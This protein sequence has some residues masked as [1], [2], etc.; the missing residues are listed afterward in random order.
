MFNRMVTL[1]LKLKRYVSYLIYEEFTVCFVEDPF[2][3]YCAYNWPDKLTDQVPP[4]L[5]QSQPNK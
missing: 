2:Y 1:V 5:D 3:Y 4:C